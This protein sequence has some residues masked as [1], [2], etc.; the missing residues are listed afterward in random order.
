MDRRTFLLQAVAASFITGVASQV[1]AT[2][3]FF[4]PAVDQL[5]FDGINRVKD[6]AKKTGLE[7]SHSPVIVA[8]TSAK[9]GEPF[10]VE[11]M[12]GENLHPMGPG[13]WIENIELSIGNEPAGRLEFQPR[14]FMKPKA[15]FTIAIPKDAAPSG[16]ITLVARQ[17]CNL[18]GLWESSADI[19]IT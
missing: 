16:K 5:L 18:H 13:H 9:S 17:R 1:S 11:I 12:V 15:V 7:K 19:S 4:Q 3:Y 2:S 14:G 6:H 8:P 10:N